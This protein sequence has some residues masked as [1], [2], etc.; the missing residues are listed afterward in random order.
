VGASERT[1]QRRVSEVLGR[2]PL[3]YVQDL[4]VDA[5]RTLLETTDRTIEEIA[6]GVGY[7]DGVTLRTLLRR[8]TGLGVRQLRQRE[9][10]GRQPQ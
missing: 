8:K 4:R 7:Q 3:S 9:V 5:A 6:A 2:S 1:L 10:D